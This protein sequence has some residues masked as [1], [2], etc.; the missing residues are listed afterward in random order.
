M[1]NGRGADGLGDSM[2]DKAGVWHIRNDIILGENVAGYDA[3]WRD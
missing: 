3:A 1:R 2:Q